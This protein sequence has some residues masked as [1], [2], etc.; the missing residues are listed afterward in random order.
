MTVEASSPV[1]EAR[2]LTRRFGDRVAVDNIHFEVRRGEVAGFL[3]PNGAGKSTTMRLLTGYLPPTSGTAIVSGVDVFEEPERIKGRIGYLPEHPPLYPEMK[4][5][6]Y[7]RYAARLKRVPPARI[8]SEVDMAATRCRVT[9]VMNQLTGDLSKGFRQRVGLAQA[10]LG[11]PDLLILDEPTA[12]LDPIQ[13]LEVREL[14]RE[15]GGSHTILLSTHILRE[16]ELTCNRVLM[17][18]RGRLIL[19][20]SLEAFRKAGEKQARWILKTARQGGDSGLSGKLEAVNGVEDLQWM[21]E[22]NH[23]VLEGRLDDGAREKISRLVVESG[24]GLVEL[25]PL[26]PPLEETFQAITMEAATRRET[27]A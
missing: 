6:E 19:Q 9:E 11:G 5:G 15:L 13:V 21:E 27:Q 16:V 22:N 3:G 20:E 4:T 25:S 26:I 14:I 23:W 18:H 24:A 17:I 12:G 1:I 7:L 2:G 8:A 10:L